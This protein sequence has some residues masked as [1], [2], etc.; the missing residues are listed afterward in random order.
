MPLLRCLRSESY[1]F[2]KSEIVI[3]KPIKRLMN[4]MAV[5]MYNIVVMV[6]GLLSSSKNIKD[7]TPKEYN[8]V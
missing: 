5:R 7:F 8:E 1:L 3:A 6:Y 4:A 2:L